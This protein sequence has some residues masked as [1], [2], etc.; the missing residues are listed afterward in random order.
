[1]ILLQNSIVDNGSYRGFR[2]KQPDAVD[3]LI[4]E[5][6][7]SPRLFRVSKRTPCPLCGSEKWCLSG[8]TIDGRTVTL[9]PRTE[10]ATGRRIGAYGYLHADG[11]SADLSTP[12]RPTPRKPAGHTAAP[13][14]Q[15]I[16]S[17][18][19]EQAQRFLYMQRLLNYR[20]Q[21]PLARELGLPA[22]AVLAVGAGLMD[23][24]GSTW[25]SFPEIDAGGR[26][27]G[28][29]LRATDGSGAKMSWGKRGFSIVAKFAT[30]L[31]AFRQAAIEAGAALVAEGPSDGA[32]AWA[33]AIPA[34]GRPSA[35]SGFVEILG[36]LQAAKFPGSVKIIVVGERDGSIGVSAAVD[37]ASKLSA[38]L[39]RPVEAALPPGNTKDTR[40]WFVKQQLNL[41]DP[42]VLKGAGKIFLANLVGIGPRNVLKSDYREYSIATLEDK[43]PSLTSEFCPNSRRIKAV[44]TDKP[45]TTAL[46][47]VPCRNRKGCPV[48]QVNWAKEQYRRL[49]PDVKAAEAVWSAYVPEAELPA[50]RKRLQ[51][52]SKALGM[53]LEF[54]MVR[55]SSG[56]GDMR[57]VVADV[58]IVNSDDDPSDTAEV[59][60]EVWEA[61]ESAPIDG[62]QA[63]SHSKGWMPKEEKEICYRPLSPGLSETSAD[64][65]TVEQIAR[66]WEKPI[67]KRG[68]ALEVSGFRDEYEIIE[69]WL[70]VESVASCCWDRTCSEVPWQSSDDPGGCGFN[71]HLEK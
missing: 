43:P 26:I 38:E 48:C 5:M 13:A 40:A 49:A 33:M 10:N 21:F 25:Y 58:P 29:G 20:G 61:L 15:P 63:V 41:S 31:E 42:Q 55:W 53:D 67:E 68:A 6:A 45:G 7:A 23:H 32:A 17:G 19:R 35:D 9:C 56:D 22:E 34:I 3:L 51:R 39:G 62:K 37:F 18:W 47:S 28:W 65:A 60:R 46:L 36:Y 59:L 30:D 8:Q 71:P 54:A 27:I 24:Y 66:A 11:F 52:H 14:G 57:F 69:F 16:Q 4:G 44:R 64:P 12:R 50:V 2:F 70:V 1:M